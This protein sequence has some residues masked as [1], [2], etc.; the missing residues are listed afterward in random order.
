MGYC[1]ASGG[2]LLWVIEWREVVIFSGLICGE[3]W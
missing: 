2:D 3:W 1:V